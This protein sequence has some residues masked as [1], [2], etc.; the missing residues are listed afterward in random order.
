MS[1]G[2]VGCNFV[3]STAARAAQNFGLDDHIEHDAR[4]RMADEFVQVIKALWHSW[5]EDAVVMDEEK[6][7][8]VDP[9]KV[10]VVDFKGEFFKSRG[11]LNTA[12]PPQGTPVLVQAGGSPQGQDFASRHMDSVIA[13]Q[14]TVP[15]AKAFRASLRKRVTAAGRDP[16]KCKVMFVTSPTLGETMEEAQASYARKAA[17]R[18]PEAV[19]AMMASLVDIDFSVYDLDAPLAELTTNGQQGTLKR[20]MA[21]GRTLREVAAN[22]TYGL[23]DFVGT[24]DYVAGQMAEAMA[25]IGGDGLMMGGPLVRRHVAEITDGL[26]PALQKRGLV[27]TGY[28]HAHFRDNLLAF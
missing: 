4:Y 17:A 12:R 25:E 22:Y 14:G 2:R 11:P 15:E 28:D 13:A 9:E 10:H 1:K 24:P 26:V 23:D 5:D 21:Q 3:T 6:G 8:F 16:D 18:K 19:L 27:R 20:F 7:I